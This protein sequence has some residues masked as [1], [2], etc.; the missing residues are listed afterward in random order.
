M[1]T[2]GIRGKEVF[3]LSCYIILKVCFNIREAER[4]HQSMSAIF[5]F[6]FFCFSL[7]FTFFFLSPRCAKSMANVCALTVAA[8]RASR[9]PFPPPAKPQPPGL[10]AATPQAHRWAYLPAHLDAT[11]QQTLRW[12]QNAPNGVWDYRSTVWGKVRLLKCGRL[13]F[14]KAMYP[15]PRLP[16]RLLRIRAHR[17]AN[18]DVVFLRLL[19]SRWLLFCLF[20]L[21]P[22][23]H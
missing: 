21:M 22:L 20:P 14:L 9:P 11:A 16:V 18:A 7:R 6:F 3:S 23:L 8:A 12:G 17:T 10:P 5:F 1:F 2:L 4:D 15:K 13:F 19:L